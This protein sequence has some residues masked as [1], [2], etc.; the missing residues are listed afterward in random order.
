MRKKLMI[1]SVLILTVAATVYGI[2][3]DIIAQLSLQKQSANLY[4]LNNF[5][6]DWTSDGKFVENPG[7]SAGWQSLDFQLKQFQIPN[8][9]TL[10][11]IVKGDKVGAAKELCAY[12]KQ[13]I[14]S[15]EFIEAYK[16]KREKAKPTS[17][18]YRPDAATIKSQ[19][20]SIKET[21]A[22]LAKMKKMKM[23]TAAQIAQIEKGIA[24]MKKQTAEWDDLAPNKTRW[25][26][27]YPE[28]ASLMIKQ[29]LEE[30][31][32]TAATVDFNATLTTAGR[33]QKFTNPA[34]ENQSLKWKAIYRAGKEANEEVTAF[35]K[36]WLKE[37]VI[38]ANKN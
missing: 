8:S 9:R 27:M 30:Y 2:A 11:A 26:K 36:N 24:D 18:P 10:S 23:L 31:L 37:G 16:A 22:N 1:F 33:K 35:V 19:K 13:Y 29:R 21:E 25:E 12:V 15:P 3:V 6:G 5:A 20:D 14:E 28:D 7:I 32:A 17:E 34:Y 38:T 4:I